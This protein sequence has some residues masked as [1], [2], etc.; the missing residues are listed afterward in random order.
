MTPRRQRLVVVAG[1]V[2]ALG[3]A[4]ALVLNALRS[5][6][7]FFYTPSQVAAHEAPAGRTFR[8]GG[9]VQAGSVQRDGTTVR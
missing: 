2:A 8:V 1:I 9:L 3:V 7:V 4:T 5:N 6:L